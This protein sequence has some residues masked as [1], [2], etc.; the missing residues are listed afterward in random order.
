MRKLWG[1]RFDAGDMDRKVLDFSTSLNVDK[2]LVKYDCIATKAHVET[3]A[4]A[5]HLSSG[6][7]KELLKA[8]SSL[9]VMVEKGKWEASG[10]ED[11]HSAVQSYVESRAP[12]A[13]KKM[14]TG[15][16][17]NEQVVNDVRLY[18]REAL[19]KIDGLIGSLQSALVDLAE[20][21]RDAIIPGYTHLNR[22][23]PVLFAHLIMSYVEMLSRDRERFREA[24]KRNDVCVMG[25][26]ALAG[27]A[28][29]LDRVFTS[30]KLGF[31][32]ISSNSMDSVSDRDIMAE[33]VSA[34]AIASVHLSRMSED[35]I[36]YGIPEFGFIEIGS[37][38]C[39]GSSLMPQKKNP[40]MLEL[41]RGRSAGVISALNS[42]LILLKGLPHTYNRD[43]QE[44]KKPFFE[45]LFSVSE[46]LQMMAGIVPTIKVRRKRAQEVMADEFIY[47]TDI[48]EYLV[49]KGVSFREAHDA[50]GGIVKYC[51]EKGINI[52]DLSIKE[53]KGFNRSLSGDVYGLL[54]P[55]S[56]VK[57]KR[58]QGST[59]PKMVGR[60]IAKWKKKLAKKG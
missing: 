16:S 6:E 24:F 51:C 48:A 27:S 22:A 43:L 14:H 52:S 57:G 1:G 44:D 41:I 53:L 9:L 8:L 23:Q 21:E 33:I 45:A 56:S 59:N 30:E 47:A 26:G 3:L 13:A 4:R 7:K 11:V 29:E 25:S 35:L 40:D 50:V 60:E 55:A 18:S 20:K 37:A 39:T 49:R 42:L 34:A 2:V 38:Y 5:G 54:N 28:L 32:D 19:S 15:R 17:R 12:R 58:T 31:S 46:C 36:L 10:F